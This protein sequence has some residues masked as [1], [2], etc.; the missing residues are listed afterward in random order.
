MIADYATL[1]QRIASWLARAD[2]ATAIPDFI[3][4]AEARLSRELR[5][6]QML[7]TT[8]GV[9]DADGRFPLP[10]DYQE[11]LALATTRNGQMSALDNR[12]FAVDADSIR[13]SPG[14]AGDYEFS[15]WARIPAL[16]D[17]AQVNWLIQSEPGA[18]LYAALEEAAPYLQDDTRVPVWAAK[19]RSIIDGMNAR[20]W[21]ARYGTA[22]R[23]RASNAP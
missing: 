9:P 2:L 1:Q 5:V 23:A 16:S 4:L 12:Y 7:A 10:A 21:G 13:V 20:D 18:Y 8:T 3:Q 19:A 6:R 14:W 22:P 15:Y 11:A 17:T